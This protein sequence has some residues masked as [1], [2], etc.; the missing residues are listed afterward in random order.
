VVYS[1]LGQL[2]KLFG[3]AVAT[4]IVIRWLTVE[5]Y[6][7]Y[8]VLLSFAP[9]LGM[10][11][12]W[13]WPAIYLRYLPVLH[14]Q[15]D[16]AEITNLIT[17]GVGTR[18]V[19][20]G[21]GIV[22]IWYFFDEVG[23]FFSLSGAEGA[24]AAFSF[25]IF[26]Y[27]I[28]QLLQVILTSVFEQRVVYRTRTAAEVAKSLLF[29]SVLLGGWGL[30]G[31]LVVE[32]LVLAAIGLVFADHLRRTLLTPG[33]LRWPTR[34]SRQVR[35]YGMFGYLGD[36]GHFFLD[37]SIDNLVIARFLGLEYVAIYSA[38]ALVA[39]QSRVLAPTALM[40][41]ILEPVTYASYHNDPSDTNLNRIFRLL[42]KLN[43]LLL[44]P[45]FFVLLYYG[46]DVLKLVFGPEYSDAHPYLV[47]LAFF[48]FAERF[49]I[50]YVTKAKERMD[51]VAISKLASVYNL[52]LSV[53]LIRSFGL[54]GVVFATG[55][56]QMM[57]QVYIYWHTK[58]FVRVS[59]PG[60]SLLAL[61][62]AAAVWAGLAR[63]ATDGFPGGWMIGLS[64]TLLGFAPLCGGLLRWGYLDDSE[65]ATV[66][67]L[68]GTLS[69]RSAIVRRIVAR[70]GLNEARG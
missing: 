45:G 64:V 65:L 1:G 31:V 69:E 67:N 11:A 49:P 24:F 27:A 70:L 8:S 28:V 47:G 25:G 10:L 48:F 18:V 19:W 68:A 40:R 29:L 63:L 35:R 34:P 16:R 54:G 20:V 44:I 15:G 6:G 32:T 17:R 39:R 56:A 52:V 66:T 61:T 60:L 57:K 43:Y 21:G 46:A 50:A 7:L 51:V 26:A 62:A 36:M 4:V 9:V 59:F 13:G 23:G 12:S 3:T 14:A 33:V 41:D 22:A 55:S 2:F 58:S 38:A 37:V 30:I 5:D 53:L 42:T